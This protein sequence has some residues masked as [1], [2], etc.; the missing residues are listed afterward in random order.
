[1]T[2]ADKIVVL[3]AG[4]VEQVGTPDD[5]YD[6]PNNTFVA[7]FIGSP[8]MNQ[9]TGKVVSEKGKKYFQA[10]DNSLFLMPEKS[11]ISEG[12]EIVFGFRPEHV[13]IK[14]SASEDAIKLKVKVDQPTGSQSLVFANVGDEEICLDVPK[15]H[16]LKPGIEFK[17]SPRLEHIHIFNKETGKRI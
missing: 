1:M 14:T 12:Q 8:S 17:M 6:K 3:N 9:L 2:M 13:D 16:L 4:I 11:N 10:K 5:L 7:S 15:S